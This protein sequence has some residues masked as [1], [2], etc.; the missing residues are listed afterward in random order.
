MDVLWIVLDSLS[1]EA[2]PWADD[3]PNTMPM[4]EELVEQKGTIF[5]RAYSPGPTSPSSHSSLFTGELP[6]QTGMHE[7]NP[8][9]KNNMETIVDALDHES[10]A[11]SSNPFVFNGLSDNFDHT[12]DLRDREFMIFDSASDP[13]SDFN[14][15]GG[16]T[17]QIVDY[18][19]DILGKEDSALQAYLNFIFSDGK[20]VRSLVNGISSRFHEIEMAPK[21]RKH[22]FSK[23][24]TDRIR[25]FTRDHPT[26][27]F[28]NY[29]DAHAPLSISQESLNEFRPDLSVEDLPVGVRG[30]EIHEGVNKGDTELGEQMFDLYKAVVWDLDRKIT[31]MIREAV[32][33]GSFVVVTA[34][35]GNW[36]R[37]DRELDEKRIHVPLIVF[38]PNR[39][40]KV[41]DKTV[42]LRSLPKTTADELGIENDFKGQNLLDV[43]EHTESVTE[44]IHN[45]DNP[46]SP[47]EPFGEEVESVR[48]DIAVV[49]GDT[50]VDYVDG[51]LR[52]RGGETKELKETI[53]KI[54]S[55]D[56]ESE[57]IDNV[58]ETKYRLRQLGY[59]E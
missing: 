1:F 36:F 42:N 20:P 17:S 48:H 5:T 59:L 3:G 6:S 35:H 30:Q 47:V 40:S 38:S 55:E 28:A 56:I 7:A 27:V 12:D 43:T 51:F 46:G 4:L 34:D 16:E 57:T 10:L 23:S 18:L 49:K 41:I 54:R 32:E 29:M 37:R 25:E 8:Y 22:R 13:I 21:D 14:D 58:D 26:F 24:I 33:S 45:P 15:Y 52:I 50:R 31:P 44:L 11:V 2:T 53:K 39:D 19:L 9:L